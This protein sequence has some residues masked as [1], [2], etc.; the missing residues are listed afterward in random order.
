MMAYFVVYNESD[1]T[2]HYSKS[3]HYVNHD[4]SYYK[5]PLSDIQS[6]SIRRDFGSLYFPWIKSLIRN[7]EISNATRGYAYVSTTKPA[8]KPSGV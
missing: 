7:N 6:K 4:N 1:G 2:M 5:L 3:K 8:K